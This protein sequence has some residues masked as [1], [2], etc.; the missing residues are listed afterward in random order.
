MG[1][2]FYVQTGADGI[3]DAFRIGANGSLAQI[4][5]VTVPGPVGGEGIVAF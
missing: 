4:G 5:S 2:T 3:V 1:S